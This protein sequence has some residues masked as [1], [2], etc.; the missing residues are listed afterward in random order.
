MHNSLIYIWNILVR[1]FLYENEGN[2]VLP[3]N[4]TLNSQDK[5]HQVM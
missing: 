3:I 2:K 5:S 4:L 1:P